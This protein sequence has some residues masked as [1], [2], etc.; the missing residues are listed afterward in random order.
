M[1]GAVH[2]VTDHAV[3]QFN[4][5]LV[6]LRACHNSLYAVRGAVQLRNVTPLPVGLTAVKNMRLE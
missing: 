5:D 3:F 6:V 1:T 2:H 4:L